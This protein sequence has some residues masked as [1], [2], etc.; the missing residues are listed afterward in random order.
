M[1][2]QCSSCHLD[3]AIKHGGS[4]VAYNTCT[5]PACH[6]PNSWT[7]QTGFTRESVCR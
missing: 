3:D 6:N 1:S 4:H 2:P 7:P 5:G